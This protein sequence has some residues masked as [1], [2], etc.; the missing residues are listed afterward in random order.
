MFFV[1]V[2]W[3]RLF[4]K[5]SA[6]DKGTL[7]QLKNV[8]HRTSVPNDPEANMQAA[9]DFLDVTL[10][11]YVVAAAESLLVEADNNMSLQEI[12]ER[13]VHT[14]V[15]VSPGGAESS[16]D[17]VHTYS[18][19]VLTLGLLWR[20]YYDAIKEG[21]GRRIMMLWKYLM[22]VFKQSG[23]RNYAKEAA[24]ML[25]NF[26]FIF[27]ERKAAQVMTSRFVNTAGRTGH[28]LPCDLH[29]EHLNRRLKGVM[30]HLQSNVQPSA[31]NRA[32]KSIG[33]VHNVCS[34]FESQTSVRKAV[35][36]QHGRHNKPSIMKDF[37]V[38][39]TVLK[40][41]EVFKVTTGRKHSQISI[42]KCLLESIDSDK[43]EDWIIDKVIP[44]FM[45]L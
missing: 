37:N 25:I 36:E 42:K 23:R 19:E 31:I 26:N 3:K 2:I 5:G 4:S 18:C 7:L 17:F 45:T 20:C 1:Q 22:L 8:L 28:N 12:A 35:N 38:V 9:E 33:V 44:H 30:N 41:N 6:Q 14:Y 34:K 16:P 13:I 29:L 24:I 27:S 43:I 10:D 11:A 21:D 32:A 15:K 39:N 40:E